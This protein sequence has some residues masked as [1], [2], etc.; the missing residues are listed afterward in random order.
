MTQELHRPTCKRPRK[1][2][3]PPAPA[4]TRRRAS[5]KI[6]GPTKATTLQLVEAPVRTRPPGTKVKNHDATGTRARVVSGRLRGPVAGGGASPVDRAKRSGAKLTWRSRHATAAAKK[7]RKPKARSSRTSE[8][9]RRLPRGGPPRASNR[10]RSGAA[11]RRTT[12]SSTAT[13]RPQSWMEQTYWD[14]VKKQK[15]T[16]EAMAETGQRNKAQ[17]RPGTDG[18]EPG[19]FALGER[20]DEGGANAFNHDEAGAALQRELE[21]AWGSGASW[22]AANSTMEQ[23]GSS[24]LQEHE[25]VESISMAKA[26]LNYAGGKEKAK[27]LHLFQTIFR[28]SEEQKKQGANKIVFTQE[29]VEEILREDEQGRTPIESPLGK[30]SVLEYKSGSA[31]GTEGAEPKQKLF[32]EQ[33]AVW[34]YAETV[35]WNSGTGDLSGSPLVRAN[36][37]PLVLNAIGMKGTGA[38]MLGDWAYVLQKH[39]AAMGLDIAGLDQQVDGGKSPTALNLFKPEGAKAAQAFREKLAQISELVSSQVEQVGTGSAPYVANNLEAPVKDLAECFKKIADKLQLKQRSSTSSSDG[40]TEGG[41]ISSNEDF[42]KTLAAHVLSPA[43]TTGDAPAIEQLQKDVVAAF[44]RLDKKLGNGDAS[45]QQIAKLQDI[46]TKMSQPAGGGKITEGA[47]ITLLK[48]DNYLPAEAAGLVSSCHLGVLYEV[49]GVGKNPVGQNG[50]TSVELRPVVPGSVGPVRPFKVTL[51]LQLEG[52]KNYYVF[53]NPTESPVFVT[54]VAGDIASQET[55]VWAILKNENEKPDAKTGKREMFTLADIGVENSKAGKE[56][57]ETFRE[58]LQTAAGGI[59]SEVRDT[60]KAELEKVVEGQA[61]FFNKMLDSVIAGASSVFDKLAKQENTPT[62]SKLHVHTVQSSALI[63]PA[64]ARDIGPML[65]N[66]NREGEAPKYTRGFDALKRDPSWTKELLEPFKKNG[67]EDEPAPTE[68]FAFALACLDSF[69]RLHHPVRVDYTDFQPGAEKKRGIGLAEIIRSMPT[70]PT[71]ADLEDPAKYP[72]FAPLFNLVADPVAVLTGPIFSSLL[73]KT[74]G[75][76]AD[77]MGENP[78]DLDQQIKKVQDA[79][80]QGT[81][82]AADAFSTQLPPDQDP[83][84]CE[85]GG[86]QRADKSPEDTTSLSFV[87]TSRQMERDISFLQRTPAAPPVQRTPLPYDA[88]SDAQAWSRYH[89]GSNSTAGTLLEPP[90]QELMSS[91]PP[92]SFVQKETSAFDPS[93]TFAKKTSS[94][95]HTQVQ[96][97]AL[98]EEERKAYEKKEVMEKRFLSRSHQAVPHM[99]WSMEMEFW[100]GPDWRTLMWGEEHNTW[101][102]VVSTEPGKW[103]GAPIPNW[104]DAGYVFRGKPKLPEYTIK[105]WEENRWKWGLDQRRQVLY[106]TV[107]DLMSFVYFRNIHLVREYS[108]LEGVM[109]QLEYAKGTDTVE[110]QLCDLYHGTFRSVR[111]DRYARDERDPSSSPQWVCQGDESG[112]P[113]KVIQLAPQDASTTTVTNVCDPL[114]GEE[115]FYLR[116]SRADLCVRGEPSTD[117]QKNDFRLVALGGNEEG[118]GATVLRRQR[119]CDSVCSDIAKNCSETCC[120]CSGGE[121]VCRCCCDCRQG[122]GRRVRSDLVVGE[123]AKA[124]CCE[125]CNCQ[126]YGCHNCC[127]QPDNMRDNVL[128]L[129]HRGKPIADEEFGGRRIDLD[130]VPEGHFCCC[131]EPAL[132]C[133]LFRENGCALG[134]YHCCRA[135]DGCCRCDGAGCN[136]KRCRNCPLPKLPCCG[137]CDGH[138]DRYNTCNCLECCEKECPGFCEDTEHDGSSAR[139]HLGFGSVDTCEDRCPQCPSCA[140][141]CYLYFCKLS[142]ILICGAYG[143]PLCKCCTR[144]RK[145]NAANLGWTERNKRQRAVFLETLDEVQ[146]YYNTAAYIATGAVGTAGVAAA[147]AAAGGVAGV[148]A[149]VGAAAYAGA[150]LVGGA[151]AGT[152]GYG[153]LVQG[154]AASAPAAA[155]PLVTAAGLAAPL[156]PAAGVGYA[157]T[158]AA[159]PVQQEARKIRTH[160][161]GSRDRASAEGNRSEPRA[162]A[163]HGLAFLRCSSDFWRVCQA[164]RKRFLG[165][166]ATAWRERARLGRMQ[167]KATACPNQRAPCWIRNRP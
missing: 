63:V 45:K 7:R 127:E 10:E 101:G 147:A 103:K 118:K 8:A 29:N 167:S 39:A 140:I 136:T 9:G 93:T 142:T 159:G 139:S 82:S 75:L 41:A 126:R 84:R 158:K 122:G 37:I 33:D 51:Q 61:A 35:L 95:E 38:L 17:N 134:A 58:V 121:H 77:S 145:A 105:W 18:G 64:A 66:R 54:E 32:A 76:I 72:N 87:E 132:F 80:K 160:N 36:A 164:C 123:E 162:F 119:G 43:S 11:R 156:L 48:P 21:A 30:G 143:G 6:V 28:I 131:C 141:L 68:V 107:A 19:S 13:W 14:G 73:K 60:K 112:N 74:S 104:W 113:R 67:S 40:S 157:Y 12:R 88:K 55:K 129:N 69:L 108:E 71:A 155:A 42:L 31:T 98:R 56:Q 97:E 154:A 117:V 16:Q 115:Y 135:I 83:M 152:A 44:Q 62:D 92:P 137:K 65:L 144:V 148:T 106:Y 2:A 59:F 52:S 111:K 91:S 89:G 163:P 79:L 125:R 102:E 114:G 124:L 116:S 90:G 150:K 133:D 130:I 57:L 100:W 5:S 153:A 151:A 23:G 24:A 146:E 94:A 15:R 1:P 109:R 165:G 27:F 53:P 70:A 81:E 4:R 25:Q 138:D 20:R 128:M 78:E 166:R 47:W 120:A 99:T 110:T 96:R 149:A 50:A 34:Q 22:N 26:V 49:L 161:Q 85:V 3:P 46:A 86:T